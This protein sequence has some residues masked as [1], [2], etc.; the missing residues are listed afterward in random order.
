MEYF[1]GAFFGIGLLFAIIMGISAS[2]W[3]EEHVRS[4]GDGGIFLM[5]PLMVVLWPVLFLPLIIG[6]DLCNRH[7]WPFFDCVSYKYA[8]QRK[9]NEVKQR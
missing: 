4:T 2:S 3:G 5:I 1:L 9:A 6:C 7:H 8:Q